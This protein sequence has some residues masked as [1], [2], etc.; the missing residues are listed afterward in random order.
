MYLFILTQVAVTS[1]TDF[2]SGAVVTSVTVRTDAVTYSLLSTF[3]ETLWAIINKISIERVLSNAEGCLSQI[4]VSKQAVSFV[5]YY[6]DNLQLN[7]I[8]FDFKT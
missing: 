4:L 6:H 1:F 8:R 5:F 3:S 7:V 2:S